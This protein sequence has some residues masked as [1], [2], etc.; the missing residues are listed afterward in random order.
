MLIF[1]I[2]EN[3]TSVGSMNCD[4]LTVTWFLRADSIMLSQ[5]NYTITLTNMMTSEV[6]NTTNFA[7][8]FCVPLNNTQCGEY[9]TMFTYTVDGLSLASQNYTLSL[10]TS[11]IN[12]TMYEITTP[13]VNTTAIT[14]TCS[15]CIN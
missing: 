13:E 12:D 6:V 7:G 8:N 1:Y 4:S 3:L 11:I 15:V 2:V 14:G 5:L 10:L 9:L